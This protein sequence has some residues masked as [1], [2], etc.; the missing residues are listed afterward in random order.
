MSTLQPDT[1]HRF[2]FDRL[3]VRGELVCLDAAF[4]AVLD[5]HPYPEP[6]QRPLGEGLLSV[7]MLTATLK[8]QGTL[9]LQ[10]QGSGP[11]RT[12]VVQG[13]HQGTVRG[14]ARWQGEIQDGGLAELFGRATDSDGYKISR[15]HVFTSDRGDVFTVYDWKQ[16]TLYRGR[17]SGAPTPDEFWRSREPKFL[18]IGG[19]S[20]AN[21]RRFLK[22]LQAQYELRAATQARRRTGRRDPS[23]HRAQ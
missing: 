13:T 3:G 6:V 21:P 9:T 15:R 23:P 14:L 22:W 4:R 16:T 2:V 5:R 11:I 10:A 20:G 19:R 17:D 7:L 1:L 8:F 18:R 12:L